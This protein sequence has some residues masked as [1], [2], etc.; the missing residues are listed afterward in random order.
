[1]SATNRDIASLRGSVN[2]LKAISESLYALTIMCEKNLEAL[3]R[4]LAQPV[5]EPTAASRVRQQLA[6][7]IESTS[8]VRMQ[9]RRSPSSSDSEE[10]YKEVSVSKSRSSL[11]AKATDSRV[12]FA[13]PVPKTSADMLSHVSVNNHGLDVA[14]NRSSV[15]R[16]TKSVPTSKAP[17]EDVESWVSGVRH[18]ISSTS[19]K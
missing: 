17:H 16:A 1:M 19:Q 5:P 12:Q 6:P 14:S 18:S 15:A 7:V 13:P 4:Q 8:G 10:D 2:E 9:R 3:E 11:A